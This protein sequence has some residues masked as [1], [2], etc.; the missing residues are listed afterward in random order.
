MKITPLGKAVLYCLVIAMIFAVAYS[1]RT[2]SRPTVAASPTTQV[3]R[4]IAQRAPADIPPDGLGRPLRVAINTWPGY[5]PG[6]L[7][8]GGLVAGNPNSGFQRRFGLPVEFVLVDD[9]AQ[10]RDLFRAGRVDVLWAT[11]DSFALE[12]GGLASLSPRVFMAFDYSHGGDGIA[13]IAEIRQVSDLRGRRV[14]FAEGTPSHYLLLYSLAAVGM[15]VEDIV[16]VKTASAI[17]AAT[18]FRGGRVD[19]AVTWSPDLETSVRERHG[20]ILLSTREA[21]HLIADVFYARGSFITEHGE[22]LSRFMAGWYEGAELCHQNPNDCAEAMMGPFH[23]SREDARSMLP[24]AWTLGYWDNARFLGAIPGERVTFATIF[25]TATTLWSSV[26]LIRGNDR[27]GSYLS[28]EPLTTLRSLTNLGW[29]EPA[30]TPALTPGQYRVSVDGGAVIDG[31]VIVDGSVDGSVAVV[32]TDNTP[33]EGAPES[34]STVLNRPVSIYFATNSAEIL[35]SLTP[36][37]SDL[38]SLASTFSTARVRITGNTDS[39]GNPERNRVLSLERARAVRDRLCSSR[40]I[41]CSRFEIVGR[42]QDNPVCRETTEACHAR[43]RR[44]DFEVLGR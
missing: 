17:E 43:N 4:T 41:P 7:Y 13:S 9:Y 23:V 2:R 3:G 42:G 1:R 39:T 6:L 21:D 25:Q 32:A 22:T 30:L 26:D 19:A 35:P 18:L 40:G 14:A 36:D 10:S 11:A 27:P 5:A 38:L 24:N 8:N 37:F 29:S 12:A 28:T 44:T 33:R 31:S 15:T 34:G 16:A 20:R